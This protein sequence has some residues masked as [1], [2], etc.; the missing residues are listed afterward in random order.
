M[1]RNCLRMAGNSRRAKTTQLRKRVTDLGNSQGVNDLMGSAFQQKQG[2]VKEKN[3]IDDLD[4]IAAILCF[5]GLAA[6][7]SPVP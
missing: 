3:E 4:R 1:R 6:T 2:H 7:Y 5:A